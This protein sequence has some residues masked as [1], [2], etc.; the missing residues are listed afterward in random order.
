MA[1]GKLVKG[2]TWSFFVDVKRGRLDG[3]YGTAGTAGSVRYVGTIRADGSAEIV[4]SGH[5]GVAE[6]AAGPADPATAYRYTM[7]GSFAGTSGNAVRTELRPY[8]AAFAKQ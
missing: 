6:P 4:A 1:R 3:Q 8:R 2:D 5:T 7:R